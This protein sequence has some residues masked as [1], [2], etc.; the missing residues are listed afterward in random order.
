[1][2][3]LEDC[4]AEVFRRSKERIKE[5]KRKRSLVL[6][7]CIPVCL[8]LVAGGFYIRPLFEP[9]DECS[10][11]GGTNEIPDREVGGF[12]Y[13]L[14]SKNIKYTSVEITDRTGDTEVVRNVTDEV[15]VGNLCSF[16]MNM[17]MSELADG[18]ADGKESD[19]I[20]DEIAVR[21]DLE[22]KAD[23]EFVFRS[24]TGETGTFRLYENKLYNKGNNSIVILSEAQQ[25]ALR[26][27]LA[28][29]E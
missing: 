2:R 23:Y 20:K 28:L 6:A 21:D 4:K 9:V 5:R 19:T 3:N 25:A 11:T 16:M 10:K 15:L 26:A 29:G 13:T 17:D 7:C 8:F 14:L 18:M 22:E 12:D 24:A 1:M 27:Q